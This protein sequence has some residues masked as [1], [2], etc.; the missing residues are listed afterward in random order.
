MSTANSLAR[1]ISRLVLLISGMALLCAS[2]ITSVVQYH[3]LS[4]GL[5]QALRSLAAVTAYNSASPSMFGDERA[6][7]EVLNALRT[8]PDILTARLL[9]PNAQLLAQY[10]RPGG[11]AGVWPQ[12]LTLPV[13]WQGEQVAQLVVELDRAGLRNQLLRQLL[14]EL[15]TALAALTLAVVLAQRLI[16]HLTQ[17]LLALTQ[18]AERVGTIG[19]SGIKNNYALRSLAASGDDEEVAQLSRSFNAMLDRL[20]VQTD[21]LQQHKRLLEQRVAQ[22]TAELLQANQALQAFNYSVVHDLRAPLRGIDGWSLA[23]LEDYATQLEPE[24]QTYLQRIRFDIQRMSQLI[25]DMLRL[26]KV[27]GTT[28]QLAPVDLVALA[29]P[30]IASLRSTQPQRQ[31][32]CLLPPHLWVQGDAPL[33]TIALTNLLDNAW[34]FTSKLPQAQIELGSAAAAA[35]QTSETVFFVRDNGAGFDMARA[36]NLF[37]PFQRLHSEQEFR[38]TGIGLATVQRVIQRHGGRIWVESAVDK[39]TTFFVA[40]PRVAPLPAA[41]AGP[42]A[43]PTPDSGQSAG[44]S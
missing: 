4:A 38:G 28:M 32:D 37:A 8:T 2:L 5:T 23:L 9:L 6:A 43:G 7:T 3:T 24:A 39:G 21:E 10:R 16:T 11:G 31:V 42:R 35:D 33:L 25:D 14:V 36:Q 44:S 27:S 22:R 13:M 40:L 17:P 20:A 1:K 19:I 30:I 15:L 26:S 12:Q 34:K 18:V 41:D 29:G